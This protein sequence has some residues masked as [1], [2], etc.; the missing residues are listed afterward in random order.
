MNAK[1]WFVSLTDGSG[2]VLW[3]SFW[4][5]MALGHHIAPNYLGNRVLLVFILQRKMVESGA[6]KKLMVS[7]DGL[8]GNVCDHNLCPPSRSVDGADIVFEIET[9]STSVSFILIIDDLQNY[10]LGTRRGIAADRGRPAVGFVYISN[11]KLV[12]FIFSLWP[13]SS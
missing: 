2:Y 7:D 6:R 10:C 11:G 13:L 1:T 4:R 3:L 5:K 8:H 12:H 9:L